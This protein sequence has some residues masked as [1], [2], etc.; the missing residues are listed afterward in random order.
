MTDQKGRIRSAEDDFNAFMREDGEAG[1]G[2]EGFAGG[3]LKRRSI[4]EQV[5]ERIMAMIKSGNLK[6]GDRLPTEAQMCVAFGISRPPLREALKALTIMGVL[7]SRQGGR[8]TVT[9]LSPTRLVAPFNTMLAVNEYDVI[10]H[11]E[12]RALVDLGLV[13]MCVERATP[14]ERQR[15]NQLAQDGHA[16]YDDPVAFRL[17]DIE[18]HRAINEGAH[19]TLIMGLAQSLYDV[20]LDMRR[21]ASALPGVIE[22]SV[23]QHC[24]V[25]DAINAGDADTAVAAYRRHLE[26]VRDTTLRSIELTSKG[27]IET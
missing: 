21:I 22:I 12:A 1:E 19:N 20:G 23:T 26:H 17:L 2:A 5:T 16:F 15:I 14:A 6:S 25:A 4:A 7:D 27:L 9:D 11:F 18:Y 10:E 24:E 13:R 3:V 8:Y